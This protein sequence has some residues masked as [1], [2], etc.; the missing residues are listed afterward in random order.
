MKIFLAT[1][2]A[3]F[4]HKEALKKYLLEMNHE[5][6]DCG[7][8]KLVPEDD[9]VP[10]IIRVAQAVSAD[11]EIK[12][13]IFGASGQGEAITAN[14]FPGVRAVVYYGGQPDIIK[15]SRQH[16]DANVLS[17]GARFISVEDMINAAELWLKTDFS[18]IERHV[19]RN[20][21]I[22]RISW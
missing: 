9:Y 2:H 12:G 18:N 10:Y 4:Y 16:N 8:D 19:R 17:F 15:L 6:H 11:G 3:G 20:K 21:E 5:V 14:R 1:D 22:D 13:I 7:A